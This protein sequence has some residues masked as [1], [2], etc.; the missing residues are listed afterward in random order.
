MS[1]IADSLTTDGLDLE[2]VLELSPPQDA[3][4]V[5]SIYLDA[6]PGDGLRTA[7]IDIKNRLS[8]LERRLASHGSP[9]RAH[10]IRD[11]IAWLAPSSRASTADPRLTERIVER[12]LETGARVTPVEGAAS[13][14]LAEASGIAAVLRW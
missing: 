4:G 3:V 14:G 11:G 2:T 6:R 5:L 9:E 1:A 12:A 7:S 8:E 13:D 10:A